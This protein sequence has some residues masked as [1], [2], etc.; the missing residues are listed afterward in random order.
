MGRRSGFGGLINAV[1][2]DLARAQRAS[3]AAHK[4]AVREG[5]RAQREYARAVRQHERSQAARTRE[6]EREAKRQYLEDQT[7]TAAD[8]NAAL[9]VTIEDLGGIL[10]Q[11]LNA[12][13]R[14]D[15]NSL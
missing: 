5:E 12:D 1:A 13:D 11:T 2:R 9:D 10:A 6:M 14:I 3:V 4:R 15:F 7:E 8:R